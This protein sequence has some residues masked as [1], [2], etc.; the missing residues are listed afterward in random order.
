[1][2]DCTACKGKG[3]HEWGKCYSC[4]GK[5]YFLEPDYE[6]IIE[7]VVKKTK[8]TASLRKSRPAVENSV[9]G[10]RIYYVW[11]LIRFHGGI[12]VTMPVI[13][14]MEI[15]GDPYEPELDLLA[16]KLAKIFCGTDMAAA[17]RWGQAFGWVKPKQVPEGL[18]L[19]AYEHMLVCLE[20]KP[21]DELPEL[22][23]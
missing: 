5:G 8:K 9:E 7:A 23:L 21:E 14:N 20:D 15:H 16:S 12:D 10:R 22:V 11:R 19:T 2:R 18:P 4:D 1:M 6:Q 17:Y 3:K 13:A